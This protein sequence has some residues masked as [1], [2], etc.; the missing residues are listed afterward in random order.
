MT[1]EI[2]RSHDPNADYRRPWHLKIV[3]REGGR[4]V[5]VRHERHSDSDVAAR[6]AELRGR[7]A[8]DDIANEGNA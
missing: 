2:T 7:N 4:L 1:I 5:G 6:I 3:T 8:R